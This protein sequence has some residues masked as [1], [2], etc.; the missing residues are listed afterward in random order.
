MTLLLKPLGVKN[1]IAFCADENT[2]RKAGV[3][4]VAFDPTMAPVNAPWNITPLAPSVLT[5]LPVASVPKKL[6]RTHTLSAD[7]TNM[8]LLPQQEALAL[9]LNA[10]PSMIEPDAPAPL[11]V[12]V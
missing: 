6:P 11:R 10:R 7:W 9:R 12:R 2:L 5:V 4:V 1:S 8:P 3:S